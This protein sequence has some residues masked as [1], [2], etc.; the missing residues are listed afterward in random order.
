MSAE[1]KAEARQRHTCQMHESRQLWPSCLGGGLSKTSYPLSTLK[2][3]KTVTTLIRN[4]HPQ[5]QQ[6]AYKG[7]NTVT[8]HRATTIF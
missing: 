6:L 3:M 5:N 1:K 7:K 2:F 4:H 8:P